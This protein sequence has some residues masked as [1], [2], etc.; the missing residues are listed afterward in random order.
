V[1]KSIAVGC[2]A[3][4]LGLLARISAELRES[5]YEVTD[6]GMS[7]DYPDVALEVD[8]GARAM[9]LFWRTLADWLAERS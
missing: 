1:E 5:G 7:V 9:A 8:L 4:G 6:H 2:D 3:A